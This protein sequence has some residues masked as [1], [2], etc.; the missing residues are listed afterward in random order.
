[1]RLLVRPVILATPQDDKVVYNTD[2]ECLHLAV[3]HGKATKIR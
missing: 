2:L 3:R 1:M